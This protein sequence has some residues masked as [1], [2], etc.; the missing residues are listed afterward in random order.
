MK[1]I[2]LPLL[3]LF[4]ALCTHAQQQPHYTQYLLNQYIINPALTGIENYTDIRF[5]HRHQW[6]GIEDAPVTSYFT[7]HTALGKKDYRTTATSFS[8]EG[9]NP[10]GKN[11]WQDYTAAPA[12]HGIG[13]QVINDRT[14]PLSNFSAFATYAY[15]IGISPRTSLSAGFGVGFSRT[16]LDASRLDIYKTSVDPAVYSGG[17]I[18]KLRPDLNAGLYLYSADYFIGVSA[19]QIIPQ[20]L[21]FSK[22]AV[23]Q[24]SGK[25]IPHLFATAGYRF[26]AGEDFNITPSVMVKYLPH[27]PTQLDINAK[28]QF[29]NLAWM[30]GGYR[31][32]DGFNGMVGLNISNTVNAS[33]SYDYTTSDLSNFS[34]GT[35]EI[36]IGFTLG[37]RYDD[38]CPRNVW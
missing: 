37:N 32:G 13:L 23:K 22:N 16:S 30:G 25:E 2:I 1:K 34:R 29:R 17:I 19:K 12:H 38:S 7:I 14:G 33:Y 3:V 4:M 20:K 27:L 24:E 9:E 28:L 11:Y 35:H 5:S 18:N 31:I 26:L 21:D 6:V 15:H 36:M 8:L 10:R